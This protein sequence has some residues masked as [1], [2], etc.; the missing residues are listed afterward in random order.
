MLLV[1]GTNILIFPIFPPHNRKGRF[2]NQPS[3][4]FS[5]ENKKASTS[6]PTMLFRPIITP[7]PYDSIR[8]S[9][10]EPEL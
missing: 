5:I 6:L 10:P 1:A 7:S 3:Q 9:P 8:L 2:H 4:F